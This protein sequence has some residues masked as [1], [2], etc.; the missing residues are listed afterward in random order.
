MSSGGE[1]DREMHHIFFR[2]NMLA[3]RERFLDFLERL[4]RSSGDQR[5]LE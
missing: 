3:L 4:H 2:N 1:S 5:V